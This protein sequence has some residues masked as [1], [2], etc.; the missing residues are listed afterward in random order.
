ML[1]FL[2]VVL[3]LAA[4]AYFGGMVIAVLIAVFGRRRR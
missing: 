1:G 3:V 2:V 4:I